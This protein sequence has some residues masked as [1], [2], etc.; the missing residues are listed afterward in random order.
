[1]NLAAWI[2][3]GLL[4]AAYLVAGTLKTTQP[5][6]SLRDKVGGWVDDLAPGV[7]RFIGA[8]EILGALGLVLP[9]L[10]G[11]VDDRPGVEGTLTGI[12]A[13]GLLVLQLL[14]GATHLRRGEGTQ[15]PV[16]LVFA[17]L[18]AFVAA[19]RFGWL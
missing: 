2:V 1:M 3:S 6:D 11:V 14:A 4:A 17:L 10:T 13:T 16:N 5:I 18:A 9:K 19:A 12:A 7:V 15:V 8:T